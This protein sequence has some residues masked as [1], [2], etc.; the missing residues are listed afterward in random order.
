MKRI[1][2]EKILVNSVI[3]KPAQ[4]LSWPEKNVE[5]GNLAGAANRGKPG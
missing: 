4:N 2:K 5:D 3:G 1:T